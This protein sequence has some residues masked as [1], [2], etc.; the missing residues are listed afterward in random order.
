LDDNRKLRDAVFAPVIEDPA[1]NLKGMPGS[2][3]E[4]LSLSFGVVTEYLVGRFRMARCAPYN[5]IQ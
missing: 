4:K 2:A 3:D 1:P 5:P